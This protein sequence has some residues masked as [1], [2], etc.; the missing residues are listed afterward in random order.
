MQHFIFVLPFFLSLIIL[1]GYGEKAALLWCYLP[2]L[3]LLPDYFIFQ[4]PH[5]PPISARGAAAAP[6]L[7]AALNEARRSCRFTRMDL[8]MMLYF[9]G[10]VV[11]ET[12]IQSSY[13]TLLV[14]STETVAAYLV[15]RALIE[16]K[17]FR[18]KVVVVLT[19]CTLL[20]VLQSLVEFATSTNLYTYFYSKLGFGPSPWGGQFRT[21]FLRVEGPYS[22]AENAG[23]VLLVVLSLSLW[24]RH[25]SKD[26][27][28]FGWE[29][30]RKSYYAQ[31]CIFLCLLLTQSRG[32]LLGGIVSVMV[33]Q[34]ARFKRKW[35]AAGVVF[36]ILAAGATAAYT[37]SQRLA[38]Q[39]NVELDE[40]T[41]SAAY[42]TVL[43]D[44]Y[45]NIAEQ[46]GWFGWGTM[47]WPRV[48]SHK[49]IDNHYLFLWVTNGLFG[50]IMFSLICLDTLWS[51]GRFAARS[52]NRED[53]LFAFSLLGAMIGVLLCIVTVF[54]SAQF[55]ALFFLVVGW[56]QSLQRSDSDLPLPQ[57][58][59]GDWR[60]QVYC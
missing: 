52:R 47:T 19:L 43:I 18:T 24:L 15:G 57:T 59:Q 29:F 55:I 36:L 25:V 34:I 50:L 2:C 38:S 45:K 54:M 3:M 42:R 37:Y 46:G 11:S 39:T 23:M 28:P 14:A 53:I 32:P 44:L 7:L 56:T 10:L 48:Q 30:I 6:L 31:G 5:M 22:G 51:L 27:S 12:N 58:V 60:P 13:Y 17:G 40:A 9:V 4:F 1:A 20:V 41:Q 49:S 8:W 26:A 16:Q 33:A 21:G 35:L